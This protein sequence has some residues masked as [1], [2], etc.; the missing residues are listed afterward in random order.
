MSFLDLLS[1]HRRGWRQMLALPHNPFESLHWQGEGEHRQP[2]SA[3]RS[4]PSCSAAA[5]ARLSRVEGSNMS[6]QSLRLSS[7]KK[8]FKIAVKLAAVSMSASGQ[9]RTLTRSFDHLVKAAE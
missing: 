3:P 8:F 4:R 9:T 6:M 5:A 7:A 1:G 2:S